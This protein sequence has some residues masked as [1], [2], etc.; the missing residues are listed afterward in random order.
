M[1]L[2]NGKACPKIDVFLTCAGEDLET[3]RNTAA[4]ACAIDYPADYQFIKAVYEELL[5]A[6]PTFGLNDILALLKQRP[7]IYALNAEYAGVNWYRNHLD[8]L[9]TVSADQTKTL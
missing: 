6:N 7:D 2:K 4:A 8:E 1:R 5:P 3:V 9:K